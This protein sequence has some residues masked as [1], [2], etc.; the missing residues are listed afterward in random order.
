[1]KAARKILDATRLVA[2]LTGSC[3]IGET[4]KGQAEDA[5]VL[6]T[7][8]TGDKEMGEAL[9]AICREAESWHSV[10]GH[11]SSSVQCDSICALIPTM[12]AS[13][14]KAGLL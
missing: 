4:P 8:E 9:K 7:R 1:M 10:H 5:A 12:K 6:I 2:R 3:V 13:L 14:R 11:G